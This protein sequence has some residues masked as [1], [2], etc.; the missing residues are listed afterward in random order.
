M[1]THEIV[2]EVLEH[3]RGMWRYRWLV[4][5]I[6][7]TGFIGGWIFVSTIPDVFRASAR[8]YVDTDT[9]LKPLMEGLAPSQNTMNEVQ[10]V[11]MAVL[12]RPNLE[13]VARETDLALRARSPE[14]MEKLITALQQDIKVTGGG[15]DNIFTIRYDDVSREKATEVVAAVLDNFVESALHNEGDDAQVTERALT[16]EIQVHERRLREADGALAKFK[17]DNLGYM[18]DQF[19]DYYA[20]LQTA[21]KTVEQTRDRTRAV[22]QRRDE[23]RRQIEGEEPVLGLVPN[24]VGSGTGCSRSAQ[25]QTLENELRTLLVQFT[26]KHPRAISIQET[27]AYLKAQCATETPTARTTREP[28][29][30]LDTNLVYQTLRVQLSTAEIELAELRAQLDAQE[31]EVAMLRRNVDKITEVEAELKQLNRDYTVVYDRHQQLLKRWEELQA[32]QRLDPVQGNVQFRRI[33]PP[34]AP[35]VPVWP[36]RA[37]LMAGALLAAI[38]TGLGVAFGLNQLNPVFFTRTSLKRVSDFPVLGSVRL[39][40]KPQQR[41]RRRLG[42]LAWSVACLL[43]IVTTGVAMAF[44]PQVVALLRDLSG[45]IV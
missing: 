19:G 22:T 17:Q 3:A 28:V 20:R 11:S 1:R 2:G 23:L 6:A 14:G 42:V 25:I 44:A 45:A 29:Q 34:F 10:L 18:P 27:I 13:N 16:G 39:I 37:V 4:A 5:A 15:V 9:L 38:A 7:W 43:L 26:D 32:K 36:N 35:A 30:T 31:N 41:K 12:T 33:E 24:S 8:V 40:E 21:I